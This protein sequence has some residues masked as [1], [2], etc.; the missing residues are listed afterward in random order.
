MKKN[1]KTFIQEFKNC[2]SIFINDYKIKSTKLVQDFRSFEFL[3]LRIV[4]LLK[5]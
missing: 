2:F 4:I 3:I 1:I 5:K